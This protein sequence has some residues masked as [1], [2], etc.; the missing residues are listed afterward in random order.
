MF[1][2]GDPSKKPAS[3]NISNVPSSAPSEGNN[4][5]K[6]LFPR[7]DPVYPKVSLKVDNNVVP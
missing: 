3:N 7:N 4:Q 5:Q 1:F 6:Y 2:R